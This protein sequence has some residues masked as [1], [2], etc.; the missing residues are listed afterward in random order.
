[1]KI[2]LALKYLH[3]SHVAENTEDDK[4]SNEAGGTVDGA[5]Q[6]DLEN[7]KHFRFNLPGDESILVAVIVELVV[8]GESQQG[9]KARPKG[10]E[11]LSGGSNPNLAI[12]MARTLINIVGFKVTMGQEHAVPKPLVQD[13]LEK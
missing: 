10:E 1:M 13:A 2:Y 8:A 3:F 6:D 5:E 4:A 11:Y 12:R 7:Q 9:T